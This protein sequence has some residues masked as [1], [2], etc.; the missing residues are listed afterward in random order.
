VSQISLIVQDLQ[1]IVQVCLLGT[2]F[3]MVSISFRH[4]NNFVFLLVLSLF[5][6]YFL[7][8]FCPLSFET[9]LTFLKVASPLGVHQERVEP[10]TPISAKFMVQ[11]NFKNTFFFFLIVFLTFFLG[12]PA[13]ATTSSSNPKPVVRLASVSCDSQM[14]MF[15]DGNDG[16]SIQLI[17]KILESAGVPPPASPQTGTTGIGKIHFFFLIIF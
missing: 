12:L 14:K 3:S 4:K 6:F 5:L 15:A 10:L 9:F 7:L 11:R 17:A 2:E 13:Y 16:F 1:S 8:L